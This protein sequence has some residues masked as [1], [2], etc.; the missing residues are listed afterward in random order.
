MSGLI[1]AIPLIIIRPF[2]PESPK[3]VA[4][5][6]AGTLQRPSIARLFSPELRGTTIVTTIMMACSYGVA[7]GAIQQM[8]QIVPGIDT[9]R[10]KVRN[11]DRGQAGGGSE[12]ARGEGDAGNRRQLHEGAGDRRPARPIRAGD[13]RGARRQP[14]SVAAHVPG[15]RAGRAAARVLGFRTRAGNGVLQLGH[16][17][18]ARIPPRQRHAAG[19]RHLAGRLL[20][21]GPVQLLGQLP[22]ARVSDAPARHGRKLR[23]QHRRPH[24]RHARSPT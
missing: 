2:L 22:A 12:D 3:W 10:K 9:V 21:G 18:A 4:K 15:S 19:N 5:R 6:A 11:G 1:P 14:A 16:E 8:P 20:H 7:F 13:A 23:R 17:L 24:V